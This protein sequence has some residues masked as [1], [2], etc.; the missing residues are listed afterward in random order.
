MLEKGCLNHALLAAVESGNPANL[1]KLILRGAT[2]VDVALVK[3]RNLQQHAVTAALLII[4]AAMEDDRILVLKLYG[5][6]VQGQQTKIPLTAKGNLKEFQAA[7][8][9]K[10]FKTVIPIELSQRHNPSAVREELLL[11]KDIGKSNGTV[12]WF[13]LHLMQLEVSWLRRIH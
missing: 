3:S 9:S 13:G 10:N 11:R 7:L 1:G 8:S 4:K 6:N 2:N 5:E 12:L